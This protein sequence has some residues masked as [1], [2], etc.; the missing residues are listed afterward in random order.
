MSI[1]AVEQN[2]M[3]RNVTTSEITEEVELAFDRGQESTLLI[4]EKWSVESNYQSLDF[5]PERVE[6]DETNETLAAT[7]S[8]SSDAIASFFPGMA[9]EGAGT[10]AELDVLSE[11]SDTSLSAQLVTNPNDTF[12]SQQFYLET[13]NAFEAYGVLGS[14]PQTN[15]D[16]T[17]VA[18]IDTGI[19]LSHPDL[20]ENIF[21][22]D[23]EANG[24]PGVDDD[25]NGFI[26]DVSGYNFFD[27]N[28]DPSP[29]SF[30]AEFHGTA[31]AGV[32]G[33]GSNNSLGI[34]GIADPFNV[35]LLPLRVLGGPNGTGSSDDIAEAIVYA[36]DNGA[37]VINLSLGGPGFS[38]SLLNSLAYAEANDVLVVAAAGNDGQNNDLFPTF[39]ASF[40]FDNILS[41]AA[42][43]ST[44]RLADFSNFGLES[45]DLAAPGVGIL[46]TIP[47]SLVDNPEFALAFID[48]TSFSAPIVAGAAA[49]L[50]ASLPENVVNA[51][52]IAI[53]LL[54]DTV[55]PVADLQGRTA[56]GG[57]LDLEAAARALLVEDLTILGDGSDDTSIGFGGNDSLNGD[58]GDDSLDGAAGNDSLSGATGND[59]LSG[60]A[61]NDSLNGGTDD[62]SLDGGADDDTLFGAG[63]TDTLIGGTGND[64]LNGGADDDTLFGSDGADALVGSV[65][66]DSLN[67]GTG[68]DSLNG[69]SGNDTLLGSDGNDSLNG[70]TG[71]DTLNGGAGNDTLFGS[72]GV[73]TLNGGADDDLLNGAADNDSL[74]GGTGNDTLLGSDGADTLSG[75]TGNDSLNGGADDDILFGSD[76][77]DTLNGG[78]GNDRLTGGSG[79]DTQHGG[80]GSDTFIFTDQFGD[81]L[82]LAFD[83]VVDVI[84]LSAVSSIGNFSDLQ[85]SHLSQVGRDAVIEAG[86]DSIT[87]RNVNINALS[88]SEFLF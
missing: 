4:L 33:A 37:D 62:D 48:G 16:P 5:L 75:F 30:V 1:S 24:T 61:G 57:I 85:T 68:N 35:E 14:L 41:V 74:N 28:N 7:A 36:V 40:G 60:A 8:N 22:N 52:D 45:V 84:D 86:T 83:T 29:G 64:S 76:G 43:D 88:A 66:N 73:D 55:R 38:L 39:P 49:V 51:T 87:L 3:Q 72:D 58:A 17:I 63:G 27:N 44:D 32:I 81:D 80:L 25:G 10:T 15:D 21:V 2:G 54:L 79:N 77:A 82:I 69:G 34:T 20:A 70:F 12:L 31:V 56:T 67:G 19:D 46:S 13:I 78:A 9:F 59:S 65:G 71:D 18:V 50:L 23:L 42:T 53:D 47:T 11:I 6:E 26:D